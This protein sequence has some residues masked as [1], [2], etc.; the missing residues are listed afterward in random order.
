MWR[1]LVGIE[2]GK[3]RIDTRRTNDYAM[4]H[5]QFDRS[6]KV[7]SIM[8]LKKNRLSFFLKFSRGR[9]IA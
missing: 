7:I 2:P 5:I 3:F 1:E 9:V 6:P 8:P 4:V